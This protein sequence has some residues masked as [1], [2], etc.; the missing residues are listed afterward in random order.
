MSDFQSG[1]DWWQASDGK[2]YP[3]E[4]HPSQQQ[5][6]PPPVVQSAPTPSYPAQTY[7]PAMAT[8]PGK[9]TSLAPDVAAVQIAH[10]L[11][12]RG[13]TITSQ[14]PGSIV[15]VVVTKNK[16]SVVV[17][18]LLFLLCVIPLIIYMINASKDSQEPFSLS[19]S[20]DGTGTRINGDGQG[21]ALML[22]NE[23]VDSLPR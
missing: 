3:S 14:T 12:S 17:A 13:A 7:A 11:S 18:I 1:A 19:L 16:P 22:I 20:A 2:W 23:V 6:P 10:M 21:K 15:G 5:A 8:R 4:L 9:Y